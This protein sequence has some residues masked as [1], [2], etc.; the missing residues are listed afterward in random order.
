MK[1]TPS[2]SL[3]A[4]FLPLPHP[5]S[6]PTSPASTLAYLQPE[7]VL[8]LPYGCQHRQKTSSAV[9]VGQ[10]IRIWLPVCLY[11]FNFFTRKLKLHS[12]RNMDKQRPIQQENTVKD[13]EGKTKR[14]NAKSSGSAHQ[15]CAQT[16]CK[17]SKVSYN[18]STSKL[19]LFLK[20]EKKINSR[21]IR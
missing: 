2:H 20:K 12:R 19:F 6:T 5:H 10:P 21:I 18:Q 16:A 1:F 13:Y 8:Q 4:P 11:H 3:P 17:F 9:P 14:Y 15:E 7:C